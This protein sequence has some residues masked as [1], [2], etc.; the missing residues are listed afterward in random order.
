MKRPYHKLVAAAGFLIGAA[1]VAIAGDLVPATVSNQCFRTASGSPLIG[2]FVRGST[3]R[4]TNFVCLAD[5]SGS[6]TQNLTGV[7]VEV[8]VGSESLSTTYTG[9]VYNAAAGLFACDVLIP[10]NT[11]AFQSVEVFLCDTGQTPNV[12]YFYPP[13]SLGTRASLRQ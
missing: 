7:K 13:Y 5:A 10:T 1:V 9:H 6:V 2:T 8:T 4:M 11:T 12:T 3:L